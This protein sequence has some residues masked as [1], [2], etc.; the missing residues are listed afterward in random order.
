MPITPSKLDASI[1]SEKLSHKEGSMGSTGR[2][3]GGTNYN[4]NL[5]TGNEN[6]TT[7]TAAAAN[8]NHNNAAIGI[9]DGQLDNATYRNSE[10]F[11][12]F[13]ACCKKRGSC[14]YMQSN[15]ITLDRDKQF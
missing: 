9:S 3:P 14:K 5:N 13:K 15:L 11:T 12:S 4:G 6:T 1:G 7:T 10:C 2:D 8:S